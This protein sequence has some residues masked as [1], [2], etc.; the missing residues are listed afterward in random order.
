MRWWKRFGSQLPSRWKL[1]LMFKQS[2]HHD[3]YYES[4]FSMKN[5]P[6][7]PSPPWTLKHIKHF[8]P[9]H[10]TTHGYLNSEHSEVDTLPCHH[11]NSDSQFKNFCISVSIQSKHIANTFL[12]NQRTRISDATSIKINSS[13]KKLITFYLYFDPFVFS[14]LHGFLCQ[15]Q[16]RYRTSLGW[17]HW[18]GFPS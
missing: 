12:Q 17:K 6:Q 5:S 9:S 10:T 1:M 14:L 3:I 16:L 13:R 18:F 8:K 4:Y 11:P 15:Q 2:L 7:P